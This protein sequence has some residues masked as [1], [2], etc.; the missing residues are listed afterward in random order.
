MNDSVYS[1][2]QKQLAHYFGSAYNYIFQR[3]IGNLEISDSRKVQ[4]EFIKG[5]DTIIEDLSNGTIS[6]SPGVGVL[7]LLFIRQKASVIDWDT[8]NGL[9]GLCDVYG[10]I[11]NQPYNEEFLDGIL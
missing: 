1:N 9:R 3:R 6:E 2:T 8:A 10:R 7:M 11:I 5:I 4:N